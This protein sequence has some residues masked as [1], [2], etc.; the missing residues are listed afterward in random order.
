[1]AMLNNQRVVQNNCLGLTRCSRIH[2]NHPEPDFFWLLT[3]TILDIFPEWILWNAEKIMGQQSIF[4]FFGDLWTIYK[5]YI[6]H[7]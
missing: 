1:M 3:N 5:P 6:N 4:I 2:Q 7:I